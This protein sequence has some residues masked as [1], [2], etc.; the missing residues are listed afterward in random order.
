MPALVPSFLPSL[1][2]SLPP[3][4]GVQPEFAEFCSDVSELSLQLVAPLDV[5]DIATLEGDLLVVQLCGMEEGGR[6]RGR[7]GE[8]LER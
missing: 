1:P 5:R 8:V 7:E 4:L 6:E 2:P 3:Y